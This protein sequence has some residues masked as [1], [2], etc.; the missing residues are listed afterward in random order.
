MPRRVMPSHASNTTT[1]NPIGGVMKLWTRGDEW[2]DEPPDPPDAS[3]DLAYDLAHSA[4]ERQLDTVDAIDAKIVAVWTAA[5]GLVA[6]LGAV[7]ALKPDRLKVTSAGFAVEDW[8]DAAIGVLVAASCTAAFAYCV[9]GWRHG[10][11][12]NDVRTA[13]ME[14]G[15]QYDA[16][17]W[18]V[19]DN[20]IQAVGRN[21]SSLNWKRRALVAMFALAAV[22]LACVVLAL[23]GAAS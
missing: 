10:P 1:I 23:R 19:V 20:M 21:E 14:H 22:E 18:G 7:L 17:K 4:V 15:D 2:P 16:I 11:D 8:L 6:I 12:A 3:P 13:L 5:S 9:R